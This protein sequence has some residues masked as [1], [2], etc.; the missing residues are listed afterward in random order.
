M[1]PTTFH[2]EG[3]N[4]QHQRRETIAENG[5]VSGVWDIG[6]TFGWLGR[7][8][9]LVAG[10]YGFSDWLINLKQRQVDVRAEM[11]EEQERWRRMGRRLVA[12]Q[13]AWGHVAR[14][15]PEG[16]LKKVVLRKEAGSSERRASLTFLCVA[17]P[18]W[19]KKNQ[20]RLKDVEFW[21]RVEDE[22]DDEM[23]SEMKEEIPVEI[24]D[25]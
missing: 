11:A 13:K 6:E 24:I 5:K 4:L 21:P 16:F 10:I 14:R 19:V 25:L 1:P 15:D 18:E 7:L 22:L 9:V 12:R 2:E 17:N 3:L 20:A 8:A 23:G